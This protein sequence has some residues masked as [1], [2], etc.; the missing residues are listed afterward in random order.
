[1]SIKLSIKENKFILRQVSLE[2]K[3]VWNDGEINISLA[4]HIARANKHESCSE[5]RQAIGGIV[6]P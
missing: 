6:L 4:C 2:L 5:K 3:Q 1:M